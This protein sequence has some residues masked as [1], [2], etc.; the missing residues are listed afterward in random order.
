M[1]RRKS[2]DFAME[3][4][5]VL[6]SLV[7]DEILRKTQD[8]GVAVLEGAK[9]IAR[10]RLRP[11]PEQPRRFFDPVELQALASS[12]LADGMQSPI[13]AYYD[14]VDEAFTIITGERRW[15]ASGIAGLERLPVLVIPQPAHPADTLGKQLAENLLRADLT[16]LE[17]AQAL[18]RLR[19][20]QPQ[21]WVEL[22]RRHGLTDR[23]L[24]Q[25]LS[26]LHAP[27]PIQAAVQSGRISGRHARAIARLPEPVQMEV[28]AQVISEGLSARAT[29]EL[30]RRLAPGPDAGEPEPDEDQAV[31]DPGLGEDTGPTVEAVAA[32]MDLTA[33]R[34]R[35]R[36]VRRVGGRVDAM[37]QQ[38]RNLRVEELLPSVEDLPEYVIRMRRLR[39]SL[40]GYIEFLERVHLDAPGAMVT[41]ADH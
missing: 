7:R 21:T 37:E 23:R 6:P 16:E 3:S 27:E 10:E 36:Q 19:D 2:F 18:A 8:D 39:D 11:D 30:C 41:P 20:I 32:V 38:L 14:D 28:L 12:L 1:S 22:A 34:N 4:A 26:L 33:A 35:R 17:K 25:M 24:H 31:S 5:G 9:L 29:E 40:N 13:T 15:R